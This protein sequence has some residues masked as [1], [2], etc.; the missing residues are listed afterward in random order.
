MAFHL[1]LTGQTDVSFAFNAKDLDASAD[2]AVQQVAVQY[3]VGAAGA[4]TNIPAGYIADATTAGSATPGNARRTSPLPA[5]VEDQASVFVRVI[6]TN[7]V[8]S[9]ELVGIDDISITADGR[10]VRP[11][12]DQPRSAEQCRRHADHALAR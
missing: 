9:D 6:T 10:H 1:D 8:G 12:C 4:F 7:A 2:D 5:A 3:R 11:G